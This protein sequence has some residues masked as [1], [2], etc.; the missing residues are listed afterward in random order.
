MQFTKVN[1]SKNR[2]KGWKDL[3]KEAGEHVLECNYHDFIQLKGYRN[4]PLSEEDK[5]RNKQ[6]SRIRI[7]VEHVFGRMSQLA[8]DRLR[9]IGKL[10]L[11]VL[12][13]LAKARPLFRFGFPFLPS[14]V[15]KR[16]IT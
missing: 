8:M 7:R 11:C 6:R 15:A 5:K 13:S 12:P 2:G 9:T 10:C 16:M 14:R 3:R 4:H 1:V